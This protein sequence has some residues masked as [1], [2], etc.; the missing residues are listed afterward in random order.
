MT[1]QQSLPGVDAPIAAKARY[2]K[3]QSQTRNHECHWPGCT[4]QVP[5]AMWGCKPHWFAL[6]ADL[7]RKIWIAYRPGQELH[8]SPSDEYMDVIDEVQK[9]IATTLGR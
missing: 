6:P 3:S 8:A 9:W 2:V 4:S 7:R 1:K 5:P